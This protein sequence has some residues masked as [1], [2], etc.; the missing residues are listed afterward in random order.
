MSKEYAP[1]RFND[2]ILSLL[3]QRQL[4]IE[5]NFLDF[6]TLREGHDAIKKMVVRGAPCIGFTA[7]YSVA[8][9]LKN[10]K[11]DESE[12]LRATNFL[13]TSRPTAVNLVYEVDR[14]VKIA[15]EAIN[16]KTSPYEAVV[17]FGHKQVQ[18][19]E[20]NNRAMAL[21]AYNELKKRYGDKKLNVLT[22]CNTGFLACGSIGTALGVIQYL[23][24]LDKVQNVWVDE[25]RPYLQGARLTAYELEKLNIPHHIVVEGA[26]TYLMSN[27]LVDA[28]FVGA[29]R[30]VAN[31]D[32]A[33][34]IGT[35]NLSI[36]AKYFDVPFYV[37]AP[38]SSFDLKTLDGSGIKI[39]LR[40]ENEILKYK[41]K[42]IAPQNSRALNP[43]FDVSL[44]Q[45]I[46]A[47]ICEKGLI[48]PD[49]IQNIKK[50]F[51]NE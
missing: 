21:A 5:E 31:G 43:S 13:K 4:P 29:D 7:I 35:A 47:L 24:E 48:E 9:W 3:D 41:D 1:I 6:S 42:Q 27:G 28:I 10:N 12:F 34:K 20:K 19:S 15:K 44:G 26:A 46:T 17:N 30:I 23:G 18:L 49:Y 51:E 39:E 11:Y 2:G 25:T 45:N 22:H 32:T 8:L 16:N 38:M 14:A 40:P 36:L 33:N 50:V 37:V